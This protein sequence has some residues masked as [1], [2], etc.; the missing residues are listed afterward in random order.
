MHFSALVKAVFAMA[1]LAQG[2]AACNGK[3]DDCCWNDEAGCDN[4]H[5]LKNP[6]WRP[7]YQANLCKNFKTDAG[8]P[9][10]CNGADCCA[11]STGWGRGC[12]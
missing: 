1:M 10:S 9:V 6:C 3:A 2:T 7:E 8:G 11:I 12:P 4:Q 5:G